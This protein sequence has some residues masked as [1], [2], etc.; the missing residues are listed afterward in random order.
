MYPQHKLCV[1]PWA[2]VKDPSALL[3]EA[4]R[5]D[6]RYANIV[7]TGADTQGLLYDLEDSDDDDRARHQR[8]WGLIDD[9]LA[10]APL[11]FRPG[12]P[13]VSSGRL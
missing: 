12:D 1:C 11:R 3:E 8:C 13:K 9:I 7:A 10:H 5:T 6:A 4:L 2:A